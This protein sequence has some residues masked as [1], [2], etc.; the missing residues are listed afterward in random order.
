MQKPNSSET[1]TKAQEFLQKKPKA[2]AAVTA[3]AP[4]II[5]TPDL[6]P[7]SSPTD[8]HPGDQTVFAPDAPGHRN[9]ADAWVSPTK[10]G[11]VS[12][13]DAQKEEFLV[14]FF[15]RKPF[16]WE[17]EIPIMRLKARIRA[18]TPAETEMVAAAVA[19]D[20]KEGIIP[21]DNNHVYIGRAAYYAMFVQLVT[22]NGEAFA[23]EL[24]TTATREERVT[25]LR[26]SFREKFE[27]CTFAL[28]S[29]LFKLLHRFETMRAMCE[30]NIDNENFWP[31]V[32]SN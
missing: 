26:Q 29:A 4:S 25:I 28:W 7:K 31:P 11:D 5:P 22:L 20:I 17:L 2:K 1:A 27:S 18:I 12:V 24:P 3:S 32:G 8:F 9:L 6:P 19:G 21:A 30:S 10:N 23:L 13:S 14:A 16:S 15:C